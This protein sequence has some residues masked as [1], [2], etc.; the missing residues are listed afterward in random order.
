[1]ATNT[2]D[3][4]QGGL[5][6][7]LASGVVAATL[8]ANSLSGQLFSP[9]PD[10]LKTRRWYRRLDKPGFTPPGPVFAICWTAI[11]LGLSYGGYRLLRRKA[12]PPRNG[13][14]ALWALNTAMIGGWSALFFGRKAL[15]PSAIAAGAMMATGTAYAAVAA[16]VDRKA[17]ATALP[18]IAWVGFATMLAE[19]VWRRNEA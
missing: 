18:F 5:S 10:H 11:E 16:K 1:M 17:A 14:V 13:A 12:S 6:T 19:E 8:V 15:G 9:S 4:P 7:A 2:L 3:D